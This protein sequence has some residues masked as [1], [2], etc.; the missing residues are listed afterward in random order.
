MIRLLSLGL[1]ALLVSVFM[2]T[3][4]AQQLQPKPGFT[5][6]RER[7]LCGRLG[8]E[9]KTYRAVE[10]CRLEAGL[11]C[12][13]LS[14]LFVVGSSRAQPA[15]CCAAAGRA[16][17]RVF[18]ASGDATSCTTA[19]WGRK[20][21]QFDHFNRRKFITLLGGAVAAWPG[22]PIRFFSASR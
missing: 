11:A 13:V 5:E 14:K 4:S 6:K 8:C 2:W 17:E 16:G 3:A 12:P 7:V 15:S 21:M 19:G 10:G 9:A 22:V 20:R 18:R 1:S